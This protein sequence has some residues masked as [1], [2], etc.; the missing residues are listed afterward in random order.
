MDIR[1]GDIISKKQFL[2]Q[3]IYAKE[4]YEGLIVCSDEKHK[5]FNLGI[6][7]DEE[8][9]LVVDHAREGEVEQKLSNWVPQ[10]QEIQ[11]RYGVTNDSQNYSNS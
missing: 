11:R 5:Q 1:K 4:E 2:E 7:L 9:I 3:G 6:Q 8:R 10:I